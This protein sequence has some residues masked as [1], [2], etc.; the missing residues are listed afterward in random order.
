MCRANTLL[1]AGR[2][3]ALGGSGSRGP[4]VRSRMKHATECSTLHKTNNMPAIGFFAKA[5]IL[6]NV[7]EP[8]RGKYASFIADGGIVR[9][10]WATL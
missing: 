8:D 6:R 10:A 3:F 9:A 1:A 7:D 2:A 5:V 4:A